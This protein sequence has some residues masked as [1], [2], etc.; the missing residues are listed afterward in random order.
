[1]MYANIN[2]CLNSFGSAAYPK[3]AGCRSPIALLYTQPLNVR[4]LLLHTGQPMWRDCLTIPSFKY[5]LGTHYI[6][7]SFK[8]TFIICRPLSVPLSIHLSLHSPPN[9]R[10]RVGGHW[11]TEEDMIAR[12]YWH[13]LALLNYIPQRG[14]LPTHNFLSISLLCSCVLHGILCPRD[15]DV[16]TDRNH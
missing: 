5:K 16:T 11:T 10:P 7:L 2:I 4:L 9:P 6:S 13:V 14:C 12:P 1:M 8:I 3:V 15:D